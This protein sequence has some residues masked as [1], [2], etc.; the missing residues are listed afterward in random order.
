MSCSADDVVRVN[1]LREKGYS[2]CGIER[3]TGISYSEVRRILG[4]ET[5]YSPP[6]IDSSLSIRERQRLLSWKAS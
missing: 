1:E 5:N 3:Y 4:L 2:L 6:A